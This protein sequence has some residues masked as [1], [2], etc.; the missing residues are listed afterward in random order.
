MS[1]WQFHEFKQSIQY[2]PIYGAII[3]NMPYTCTCYIG[4]YIYTNVTDIFPFQM[5]LHLHIHVYWDLSNAHLTYQM[6]YTY[7]TSDTLNAIYIL[8][9]DPK[10]VNIS[11]YY[12][13]SYVR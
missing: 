12:Y 7:E 9:V 8:M 1:A 11:L 5:A 4:L 6:H 10:L 2:S 13:S 3:P